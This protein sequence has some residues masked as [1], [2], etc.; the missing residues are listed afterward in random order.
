MKLNNE[1]IAIIDIG[2]NSVRLRLSLNER[3]LL[4]KNITTQLAS[5]MVGGVLNE[6][7]VKRTLD[8]LGELINIAKENNAKI[9]VFATAAVRNSLNGI[10]FCERFTN[11]YGIKIDVLSGK[12]EAEMGILG[13]LE[14]KDGCV[15]DVGGASSELVIARNGKI[16]YAYSIPIGAVVLTD[17][18]KRDYEGA[19]LKIEEEIKRL[20]PLPSEIG[21]VYAIGGTAN[22]MAFVHSGLEVFNRDLTSGLKMTANEILLM[23]KTFYAKSAENLQSDY[24]IREM[25]SRVIHS[26][27]LI[28]SRLVKFINAKEV[29][30][31][32]N[33]NLEGYYLS[34]IMGKRY[35]E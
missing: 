6:E 17:I 15:I 28:I 3:V 23:A 22:N 30:F 7:S 19:L 16:V 26:G 24:K 31:T 27:A 4:R 35:E 12:K 29:I 2:S 11:L 9:L 1:Y 32:E 14:G 18:C 10:D 20:P 33:D 34:K 5:K 21:Q 8:G 25:R 13:A